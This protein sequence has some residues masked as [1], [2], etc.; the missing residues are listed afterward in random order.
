MNATWNALVCWFVLREARIRVMG[1]SAASQMLN[2]V[3]EAE[4]TRSPALLASLHRALAAAVVRTSELH[5]NHLSLMRELRQRVGEPPQGIEVDDSARFSVR[6]PSS[7]PRSAAP[8]CAFW[9]SRPSSMAGSSNANAAC[10]PKPTKRAR[11]LRRSTTSN[12]CVER[13]S[14]AI[15]SPDAELLAAAS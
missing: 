5:P 14:P 13:S 2:I 6:S 7:N 11:S 4:P 3:F 12:V 1:P 10:S 15:R 8:R 9:R